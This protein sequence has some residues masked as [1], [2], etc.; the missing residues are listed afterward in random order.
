MF[1]AYR[2]FRGV[3][4]RDNKAFILNSGESMTLNFKNLGSD[5]ASNKYYGLGLEAIQVHIVV[6]KIST[7]TH[8]NTEELDSPKT[9]GTANANVFTR[10]IQWGSIVVAAD[11][12]S[13]SF[14]V[15]AM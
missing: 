12:D 3:G 5:S 9:L 13:T 6:S 14:E 1:E 4:K 15:Y 8:I 2:D 10:G 7:I 11:Q